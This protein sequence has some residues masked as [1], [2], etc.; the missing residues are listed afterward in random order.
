MSQESPIFKG[1][2]T[3][4]SY[5]LEGFFCFG[6]FEHTV[7]SSGLNWLLMC[8]CNNHSSMLG[9]E[10]GL[11]KTIQSTGTPLPHTHS[12]FLPRILTLCLASTFKFYLGPHPNNLLSAFLEQLR[13][14]YGIPG[15]FLIVAPLS[16]ITQ[17]KREIESWTDINAVLYHVSPP[18]PFLLDKCWLQ[19][20][21]EGRSLMQQF[22]FSLKGLH[23][24]AIKDK[25]RCAQFVRTRTSS[26][27][28]GFTL[29][30]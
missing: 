11:G 19:G 10:M 18:A 28:S 20:S 6:F 14:E 27:R 26:G 1:K 9:D 16:T 5:Q 21:R 15:P 23:G 12:P 22:E 25:V 8:W 13:N 24:T 4:R 2:N 7:F 29:S 3:L 30:S 17:W